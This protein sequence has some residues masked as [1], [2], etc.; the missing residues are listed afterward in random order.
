MKAIKFEKLTKLQRAAIKQLGYTPSR[1]TSEDKESLV[2][3]LQDV[4]NHGANT[5][6]NGFIYY[7]ETVEFYR[8]NRAVILAE[9]KDLAESSGQSTIATVSNFNCLVDTR[10]KE[11]KCDYTEDEI[12]KALYGIV[13]KD[14]ASTMIANALALFALET[15]ADQLVNQ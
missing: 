2:N 1:L 3:T 8:K 10:T 11:R 12:G 6:H 5:G 7:V 14:D 9:L 4:C 13:G 15:V